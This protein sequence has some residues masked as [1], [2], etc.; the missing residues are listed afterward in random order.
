[1]STPLH[2]NEKK[3]VSFLKTCINGINA[4]SGY[5]HAQCILF[6]AI[7]YSF[8]NFQI[9]IMLLFVFVK[10]VFMREHELLDILVW[11]VMDGI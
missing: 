3:E 8:F 7:C 9:I 5:H 6:F 1:M 11:H 4:L 10:A 2:E